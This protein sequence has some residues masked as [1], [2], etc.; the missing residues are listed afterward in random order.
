MVHVCLLSALFVEHGY[1]VLLWFSLLDLL[2]GLV[3]LRLVVLEPNHDSPFAHVLVEPDVFVLTVFVMVVQWWIRGRLLR[4]LDIVLRFGS[5]LDI[6]HWLVSLVSVLTNKR[7]LS[8]LNWLVQLLV[9]I[10]NSR[11]HQILARKSQ[12]AMFLMSRCRRGPVRW[13]RTTTCMVCCIIWNI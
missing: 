3:L 12:W 9:D 7:W 11:W 13:E 6:W 10:C 5:N 1:V 8:R 4:G 2:H